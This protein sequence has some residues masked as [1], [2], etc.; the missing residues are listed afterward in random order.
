MQLFR[1]VS[2]ALTNDSMQNKIQKKSSLADDEIN[3]MYTNFPY[4]N[5]KEN[6]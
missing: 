5:K 2:K 3:K 4:V 1:N 6:T